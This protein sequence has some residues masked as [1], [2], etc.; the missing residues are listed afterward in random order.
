MPNYNTLH[1]TS[2]ITELRQIISDHK[3]DYALLWF[4]CDTISADEGLNLLK[5]GDIFFFLIMFSFILFELFR[6]IIIQLFPK[7]PHDVLLI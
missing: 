7:I 4:I 6:A 2:D 1:I 3:A 5:K